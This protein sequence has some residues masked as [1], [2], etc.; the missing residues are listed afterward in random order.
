MILPLYLF[1]Q[2]CVSACFVTAGGAIG[3]APYAMDGI[4]LSAAVLAGSAKTMKCA[5]LI[6]NVAIAVPGLAAETTFSA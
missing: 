3:A 6:L 1:V 4:R 5:E 2:K